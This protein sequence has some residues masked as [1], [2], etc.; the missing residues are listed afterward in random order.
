MADR[1][2]AAPKFES[3]AKTKRISANVIV[4]LVIVVLLVLDLA[5]AL[6]WSRRALASG[7]A[8]GRAVSNN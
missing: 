8:R 7:A 1:F 2:L 5:L 3:G 4:R 6:L